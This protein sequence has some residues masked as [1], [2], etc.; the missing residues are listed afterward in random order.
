MEF[1]IILIEFVLKLFFT[2]LSIEI[3]EGVSFGLLVVSF[4]VIYL[5][6]RFFMVIGGGKD[7][8]R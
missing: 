1:F 3:V 7:D 2:F 6:I 8:Y 5:F 4:L